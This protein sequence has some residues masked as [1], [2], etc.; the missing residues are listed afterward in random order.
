MSPRLVS[1]LTLACSLFVAGCGATPPA[2]LAPQ[3]APAVESQK[4][5]IHSTIEILGIGPVYAA[6][7]RAQGIKKVADLLEAGNTR[8]DRAKLAKATGISPKLLMTWV[9][10]SDLMRI[11]QV[12]PVYSRMLE[13]AG[14]DTVLELSTRSPQNLYIALQAVKTKGGQNMV[15]RMPSYA[16]V[17]RWVDRARNFG[18]YVEY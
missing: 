4:I 7:L 2:S 5:D 12:G 18:R 9:N 16:T 1:L 13:D 8:A 15:D 14:V 17:A 11:T 6:A 3:A 10:H